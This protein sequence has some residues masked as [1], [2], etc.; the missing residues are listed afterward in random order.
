MAGLA[1]RMDIRFE[2]ADVWLDG[3]RV[4][5]A[6]RSEET[7]GCASRVAA[8]PQVRAALLNKQHAF[9]RAPG[10]V[11]DGRDMASVVFP[12]ALAKVFL[13]ASAEARAERRYKQLKEKGMDANIAALLQDIRARDERDT[14]RSAAPLQKAPDASLLDTTALTIEQAV[15]AVLTAYRMK[16]LAP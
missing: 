13:T 14:Q 16:C 15:E 3:L 7:G 11:T 4:G 1:G 6:L 2:G 8:L 12:D 5:D 10:L 9:R